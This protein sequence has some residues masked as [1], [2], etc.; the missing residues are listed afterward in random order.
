MGDDDGAALREAVAGIEGRNVEPESAFGDS[1]QGQTELR[2]SEHEKQQ[3]DLQSKLEGFDIA[4]MLGEIG[5]KRI[6]DVK[7]AMP[8][9]WKR[10]PRKQPKSKLN[11]IKPIRH[12]FADEDLA[13][14]GTI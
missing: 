4:S 1:N 11:R 14:W 6:H 3:D 7:E 9:R 8:Y 10:K 12:R 13:K 2:T 5:D